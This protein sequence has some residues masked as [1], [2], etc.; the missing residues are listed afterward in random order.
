MSDKHVVMNSETS[1][2]E[3]K[4]CGAAERP[5]LPMPVDQM[6]NAMKAFVAK[7][8]HCKKPDGEHHE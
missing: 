6:V 8:K 2:F 3:C 4:H 1:E 5:T 7:H